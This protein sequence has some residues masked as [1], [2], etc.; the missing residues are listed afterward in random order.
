MAIWHD[1]PTVEGLNRQTERDMACRLG[2][3]YTEVG[4]DFLRARIPVD[5]RT[6][7]PFGLLHGGVSC[8][9]AESMGSTASQL[10]V[11]SETHYCVG[12]EINASHLRGV[13]Q[14][15]VD[16]IC[17]PLRIGRR[18][19]VWETRLS[20]GRGKL[21]CVARLSTAVVPLR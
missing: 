17:R 15:W 6:Q 18:V 21:T 3:E 9:V 10:C 19:Q 16:A 1:Q 7:Q 11:D 20:D 14:G 5:E 8:V 12:T 13:T 4:G 2:L